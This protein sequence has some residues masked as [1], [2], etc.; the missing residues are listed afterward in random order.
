MLTLLGPRGQACDGVSRRA[1]LRA[2]GLSL[3]GGLLATSAGKRK[4]PLVKHTPRIKSVI[5][6]DLFGGP[7]HIDMFDPKPDAPP[8]VR[9]VRLDLDQRVRL[10]D[11]R[12]LAAHGSVDETGHADSDDLASVQQPQSVRGDDRLHRRCRQPGLL[13]AA[14]GLSE[15]GIG[16]DVLRLRTA[17]SAALHRVAGRCPVTRK[18]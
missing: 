13:L 10:A 11:L 12:A 17:R 5:L 3:F 9:R 18:R 4:P 7:S 2:G 14:D 1:I 8:E 16:R 15:H 6:I